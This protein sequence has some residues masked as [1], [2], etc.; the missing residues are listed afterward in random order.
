MKASE[1]YDWLMNGQSRTGCD[2]FDAHV[3]ASIL[4]LALVESRA[5]EVPPTETTGLNGDDLH[6]LV[7]A[8]FPRIAPHFAKLIGMPLLP[9]P[10]EQCQLRDYIAAHATIGDNLETALAAMLAR[11]ALQPNHLWQDL[12]LRNRRELS[13]LMGRHFEALA[14]RNSRDMKWKKFLYR[15][16]CVEDGFRLCT[17]PVCS[18]CDDFDSCFGSETGEDLLA[19][20]R[21]SADTAIA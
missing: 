9:E 6:A 4:A 15:Q 18:E 5:Q 1:V 21:R 16:I 10:D 8:L 3:V 17:A 19:R 12:G 13:W 14:A 2:G 11:R 20:G 7:A